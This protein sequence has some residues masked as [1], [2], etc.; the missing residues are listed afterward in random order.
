M[1]AMQAIGDRRGWAAATTAVAQGSARHRAQTPDADG[2]EERKERQDATRAVRVDRR[3]G[4]GEGEGEGEGG[5]R[6]P[7]TRLG[8][9]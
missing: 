2:A 3:P 5:R 7:G 9:N 6:L 1:Q 4:E 8:T